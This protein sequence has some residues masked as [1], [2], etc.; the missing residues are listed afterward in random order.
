M[1]RAASTSCENV[2]SLPAHEGMRTADRGEQDFHFSIAQEGAGESCLCIRLPLASISQALATRTA[3]PGPTLA[4][5][6]GYGEASC[7]DAPS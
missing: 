3:A 2:N 5:R 6:F 1:G 4:L 7:M